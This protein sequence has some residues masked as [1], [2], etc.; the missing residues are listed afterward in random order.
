MWCKIVLDL[1]SFSITDARATRWCHECLS[2]ADASTSSQVNPILWRSF[3]TTFLQFILGLPCLPLN[4]ATSQCSA[5]FGI[6]ILRPFS[7]HDQSITSFFFGS[8]SQEVF[9]LFFSVLLHSW[10]CPSR[11]YQEYLSAT[12]GVLLPVSCSMWRRDHTSAALHHRRESTALM[13]HTVLSAAQCAYS[14]KP[15]SSCRI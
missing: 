7:R 9:I 1:D 13:L 3:F 5:C 8:S 2:W 12:C 10:L 14:S 15:F 4:P 6:R 11:W